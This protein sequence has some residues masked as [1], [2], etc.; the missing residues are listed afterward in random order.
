[1]RGNFNKFCLKAPV[2]FFLAVA[3]LLPPGVGAQA[4]SNLNGRTMDQQGAVIP[5]VGL[6][7]RSQETGFVRQSISTENGTFSFT[8]LAPGLYRIEADLPGF[9]KY[10]ASN[11]KL[12]IGKTAVFDITLEI[13]AAADEITVIGQAPLVDTTSNEVGGTIV[14]QELTELPSI[15]RNFNSYMALLPGVIPSNPAGNFGADNVSIGGQPQGQ[16]LYMLDG[17]ANNDDQR[18]GGSGSQARVPL[19]A[20]Q[21]F[22]VLQGQFSA[23]F[24][25]SGGVLNAV[26]RSGTNQVHGSAFTLIRD[27][28]LTEN[29]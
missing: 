4:V 5:G 29:T 3:L 25:G 11:L 16:T 10:Q 24:S 19:E 6:T 21:E 13:G 22:Q 23:E 14:V 15:N 27:S 17:A 1:M 8:G 2:V 18:G 20:I 9:K 26:S 12:E 7:L 28:S